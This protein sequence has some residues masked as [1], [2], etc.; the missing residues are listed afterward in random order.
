MENINFISANN[1]PVAEGDEVSVL[2]VENGELKQKSI[3]GLDGT[4]NY[5]V[6]V[7]ATY[8]YDPDSDGVSGTVEYISGS[9]E[10][11]V[12]VMD[13]GS[14]PRALFIECG[15]IWD[16]REIKVVSECIPAWMC[17]EGQECLLFYGWFTALAFLDGTVVLE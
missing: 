5:D 6:V 8:S 12:Q 13:S 9:F 11:V 15:E 17:S 1:L 16:G 10:D 14:I 7:R 4:S 3:A 2:C